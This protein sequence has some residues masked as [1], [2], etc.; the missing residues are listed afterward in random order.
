MCIQTP[1]HKSHDFRLVPPNDPS[2]RRGQNSNSGLDPSDGWTKQELFESAG[3]SPK[4]FDLIRK[5]ARIKG[6]T[7]GGSMWVFSASDVEALIQRAES[8]RFSERGKPAGA[9]WRALLAERGIFL[10]PPLTGRSRRRPVI[11]Q[12]QPRPDAS[13][14]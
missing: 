1:W 6:P 3:F 7:H 14:E 10:E 2:M 9:A 13:V 5:A 4:T 8:G 11:A 12:T